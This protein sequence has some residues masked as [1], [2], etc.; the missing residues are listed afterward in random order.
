LSEIGDDLERPEQM[1]EVV[2]ADQEWEIR[3][4]IEKE[5]ADGVVHY[6]VEYL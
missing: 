6:L 2:D 5:D 1:T 3:D 4:I